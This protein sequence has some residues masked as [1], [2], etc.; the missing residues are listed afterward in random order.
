M[1]DR[2]LSIKHFR[3]I[4][5]DSFVDV[6]LN[7]VKSNKDK[8]GGLITFIGEN[9][10]GKSNFLDAILRLSDKKTLQSDIP[11]YDYD[12]EIKPKIQ[13]T[14]YDSSS[15]SKYEYKLKNNQIFIDKSIK[16]KEVEPKEI[17][18]LKF[19]VLGTLLLKVLS[20]NRFAQKITSYIHHGNEVRE[21]IQKFLETKII[22]H[23]DTKIVVS[24]LNQINASGYSIQLLN[25]YGTQIHNQHQEG[26]HQIPMQTQL[27]EHIPEFINILSENRG[28]DTNINQSY[29]EEVQKLFGI[30][31]I[32]NIIAYNDKDAYSTKH[33]RYNFSGER[34]E[35]NLLFSRLLNFISPKEGDQLSALF[36]EYYASNR[37]KNNRL[38]N[39]ENE[40]NEKLKSVS[41]AFNQIY[42]NKTKQKYEFVFDFKDD[43]ILLMIKD[44][45]RAIDLDKQSAGFKWFFNFFINVLSDEKINNGDIVI[46][47]E[48]ATNLHPAAQIEL[49][50]QL[51][52]FGRD[53]GILFLMSTHSPFM[54]DPDYF[55][56]L[57]I[58]RRNGLY[59]DVQRFTLNIDS[60]KDVLLPIKSSLTVDKHVIIS[61][62]NKTIYVE[63]ITDYNYLTAFKNTKEKYRH[64]IFLPINGVK[65]NKLAQTLINL[66]KEPIALFDADHAGLKAAEQLEKNKIEVISLNEVN[67]SFIQIEDLFSKEDR[68]LY[69][70]NEDSEKNYKLSSYF[71]NNFKSIQSKLGKETKENF[72]LLL[73]R[74]IN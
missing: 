60:N 38:Y 4:G 11:D 66:S 8:F 39:K 16:G 36:K 41:D 15:E 46:L 14:L 61:P 29:D 63:G 25:Q 56:Q 73:D 9:N 57:R 43:G 35:I 20:D 64:L 68:A 31:L 52:T 53:H 18:K 45:Q 70:F 65:D 19:D 47:D 34:F 55:D 12:D 5:K 54:I 48:P 30:K 10:S 58:V 42:T 37:T 62:D 32:P 72:N 69:C 33:L 6:Q 50:D 40:L 21:I 23:E 17:P 24:F 27:N 44:N 71:K 13:L 59:A 74:L 51:N 2:Y 3:N 67:A 49:V 7:S 1:L 22:S 28:F 26:P